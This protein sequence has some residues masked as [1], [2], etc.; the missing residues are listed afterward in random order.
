MKGDARLTDLSV[1]PPDTV[2]SARGDELLRWNALELASLEV[3]VD[4]GKPPRVVVGEGRLTDFYAQLM[5]S[6]AGRFN[7]TQLGEPGS[8]TPGE[9]ASAASA[10]SAPAPAPAAAPLELSVGGIQL[11][12]GRIDFT[13][14]FVRPN[15]S[16]A[17]T[18][19]NGPLG[20]FA[21]ASREMA[22]LELRGRAEGTA[23]LEIAARS[24]RWRE[25]LALDIQ[26]KAT[27]LELAPLSPYA[28]KYAGYAI[29]RGKL[30]IDVAYKIDADGQLTRS[31]QVVLNQLTFGDRIECADATKLPVKLAVA[32]LKD[33]HGV[34]DL[35]LPVSGSINDPQF[36][37]G[38]VIW[39]VIVNLLV[40]AVTAPFALLRR[41]RRRRPA[42]SS[43]SPA[44]PRWPTARGGDRQGR[45]GAGRRPAL[46]MTVTG[47]ADPSRAR[48]DQRGRV[49]ARCAARR[50]NER[51][52]GG[53]PAGA[54]HRGRLTAPR[55][56]PGCCS[57]STSDADLP[58]KP[59]N[60]LGLAKDLPAPEMEALLTPASSSSTTKARASW[61]C[62]AASRC[63]TR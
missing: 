14:H 59:R 24:T 62:S 56:A 40:K 31:N 7:F 21:S 25:P 11:V 46:K 37:V 12:N 3:A 45:H 57:R 28:G 47:A 61:R 51:C 16:A 8:A 39:K 23:L 54:A 32:L 35:D 19:L 36:S 50:R 10:A 30:S 6:E 9:A 60:V 27:D 20:A 44:R 38:G 29:E 55:S 22:T 17:L 34:I 42:S 4:P 2:A 18:E 5:V 48:R 1:Y 15:Y 53:A 49:D 52:E 43:S 63:A 33:R 13:D 26:A 41:R 58:D